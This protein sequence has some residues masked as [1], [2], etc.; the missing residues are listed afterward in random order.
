MSLFSCFW[1]F[2]GHPS[3][4]PRRPPFPH[5]AFIFYFC[6]FAICAL[7]FVRAHLIL[8]NRKIFSRLPFFYGI[9]LLYGLDFERPGFFLSRLLVLS[10]FAVMRWR[11]FFLICIVCYTS[12]TSCHQIY[13]CIL[14]FQ[15]NRR[16]RNK[17]KFRRHVNQAMPSILYYR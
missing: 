9:I 12:A 15:E 13:I 17:T 4:P 5:S 8:N 14:Y 16:A 6:L 11:Q 2:S 10:S 1:I 3:P 7:R